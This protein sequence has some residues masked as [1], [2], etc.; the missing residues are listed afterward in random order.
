MADVVKTA[1][2]AIPTGRDETCPGWERLLYAAWREER[3]DPSLSLQFVEAA[4]K[5][6]TSTV[7]RA[8]ACFLKAKLHIE[9]FGKLQ[10]GL[11]WL[12]QALNNGR[13][14]T[15]RKA[16]VDEP[17][18]TLLT[19]IEVSGWVFHLCRTLFF[20]GCSSC[21]LMVASS[22]T[23][24]LFPDAWT[25]A[26]KSVMTCTCSAAVSQ[27]LLDQVCQATHQAPNKYHYGTLLHAMIVMTTSGT[28]DMLCTC[29]ASIT[30]W[31]PD[32]R[33]QLFRQFNAEIRYATVIERLL[34]FPSRTPRSSFH[35]ITL[36]G[37]SHIL[38]AAWHSFAGSAGQPL[39]LRPQLVMGLKAWHFNP[40]L[41]TSRE[42]DILTC[43]LPTLP[44]AT[45][46][47]VS[48]G[49]IDLRE[50][51]PIANLPAYFNVHRPSKYESRADAIAATMAA[52]LAGLRALQAQ[53]Q[54][55]VVVQSVRPPPRT[56][57][58]LSLISTIIEQWNEHLIAAVAELEGVECMHLAALGERVE[59]NLILREEFDILDGFHLNR[60]YLHLLEAWWCDH[61]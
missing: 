10:F 23:S 57:A 48:A 41:T 61:M 7:G 24:K 8:K 29:S 26:D 25:N 59:N 22:F 12:I 6:E 1:L 18:T 11:S 35:Q 44:T 37:D 3:R 52:F 5:E 54:A 31:L 34:P 38:P 15:I 46:I 9:G 43:K 36:L 50:E 14:C 51:G 33:R 47:L 19:P 4:L 55:P 16:E 2:L 45:P 58:H 32:R 39:Q 42:R 49:E 21:S 60:N 30:K 27:D 13:Q 53:V 56:T 20:V 40:A 17:K 28:S